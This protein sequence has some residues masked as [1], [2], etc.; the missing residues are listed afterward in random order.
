MWS[1]D[2]TYIWADG[3]WYYPAVVLNL[4]ARR[5]V[6]W[7]MS[8]TP[9]AELAVKALGMANQQRGC[10]SDVRSHSDQGSQYG[11]VR[12]GIGCDAIA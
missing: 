1:G 4:H 10:P 8:D 11:S 6:D 12:F 7:A 3:R 5:V 9:D 2:I